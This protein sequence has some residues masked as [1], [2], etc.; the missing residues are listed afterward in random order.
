MVGLRQ[1][2]SF[3]E[4]VEASFSCL[5]V[6]SIAAGFQRKPFYLSLLRVE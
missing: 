1:F 4:E 5:L 3:G 6:E 2:C